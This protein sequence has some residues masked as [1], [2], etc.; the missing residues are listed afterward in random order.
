MKNGVRSSVQILFVGSLLLIIILL[1]D[2]DYIIAKTLN[3]F[4]L[5]FKS[6]VSHILFTMR[7]YFE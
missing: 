2:D 7:N 5:S 4:H 6:K 3:S 1:F